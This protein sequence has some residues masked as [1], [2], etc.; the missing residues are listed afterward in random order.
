MK[1]YQCDSCKKIISNPCKVKM[2][3]FYVGADFD[4]G[5]YFPIDR[6]QKIRI[7][8][9]DDCYKGLHLIAEKK[10]NETT[11]SGQNIH[12]RV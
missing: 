1:V 11:K 3:E 4:I 9:C 5:T 6:I 8:L 7:H 12:T 10:R 2:K